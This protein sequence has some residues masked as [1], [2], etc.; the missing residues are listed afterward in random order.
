VIRSLPGERNKAARGAVG[1]AQNVL[2]GLYLDVDAALG[3][4]TPSLHY[5]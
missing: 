3:E 4:L 2:G 5:S 1:L